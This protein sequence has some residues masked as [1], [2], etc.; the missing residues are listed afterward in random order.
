MRVLLDFNMIPNIS[1]IACFYCKTYPTSTNIPIP[2]STIYFLEDNQSLYAKN[3][4]HFPVCNIEV[5]NKTTNN[6]HNNEENINNTLIPCQYMIDF[7]DNKKT[8]TND[9]NE[10]N[11]I[12][13]NDTMDKNDAMNLINDNTDDNNTKYASQNISDVTNPDT[14]LKEGNLSDGN[15]TKLSPV[16]TTINL[17]ITNSAIETTISEK[18]KRG[19]RKKNNRPK[20]QQCNKTS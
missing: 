13:E 5:S 6:N 16:S 1:C 17:A 14:S 20:R 2:R 15:H 11:K 4:S 9:M 3:Q 7:Q 10:N 8:N 19:R 12:N 18:P